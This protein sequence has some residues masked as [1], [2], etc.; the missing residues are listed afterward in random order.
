[1]SCHPSQGVGPALWQTWLH[2]LCLL[3][4]FLSCILLG[5]PDGH[6]TCVSV[7]ASPS[8]RSTSSMVLVAKPSCLQVLNPRPGVGGLPRVAPGGVGERVPFGSREEVVPREDGATRTGPPARH[9]ACERHLSVADMVVPPVPRGT[10][11]AELCRGPM[12]ALSAQARPPCPSQL[13][14]EDKERPAA[15]AGPPRTW[16]APQSASH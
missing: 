4:R 8:A 12:A 1:M 15:R 2:R 14:P 10:R 5:G 6:R 11:P 7:P 16:R 3:L 9:S 13:R